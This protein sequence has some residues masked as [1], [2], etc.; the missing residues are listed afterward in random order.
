MSSFVPLVFSTFGGISGC[1]D[2][3]HTFLS[4]LLSLKMDISYSGIDTLLQKCFTV[5]LCMQLTVSG[6]HTPGMAV[7]SA[8]GISLAS[9][10]TY[11]FRQKWFCSTGC[12]VFTIYSNRA[13]A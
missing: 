2:V 3:V 10:L 5:V 12:M 4:Y 7:Q 9:I 1:T 6:K 8:I 13:V 11:T